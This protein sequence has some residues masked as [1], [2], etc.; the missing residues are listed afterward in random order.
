[1]LETLR[2]TGQRR[3]SALTEVLETQAVRDT[4]ETSGAAATS[5]TCEVAGAQTLDQDLIPLSLSPNDGSE[6]ESWT[7]HLWHSQDVTGVAWTLAGDLCAQALGA[8]S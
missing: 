4:R 8:V 7:C 6:G 2:L 5:R 3:L 1:M